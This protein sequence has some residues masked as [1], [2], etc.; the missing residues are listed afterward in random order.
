MD[1]Q[2]FQWD[3][4]AKLPIIGIIRNIGSDAVREILP[5]YA[6]AG[7][8]TLEITMNTPSATTMIGEAQKT[9][10][11]RLQIGAGTVCNTRELDQALEAGA[12]FIV[13][14]LTDETIIKT[15]VAHHIPVFPGAFTPSE[16]YRAWD[17][18]A[19]MIKIFPATAMG[20]GYIRDLKGPFPQIK[21]VPT[22]GI[23]LE[24][25][26]DYLQAGASG[27]GMG[28][29]L[30]DKKLISAGNWEALGHRFAT[31]AERVAKQV[32]D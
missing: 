13:T 29:L 28:S 22:G 31:L 30:F 11:D 23:T 25:C 12:R 4:F 10:G 3:R 24:N 7:L 14:P 18:G 9:F 26:G 15:C 32:A 27:L 17:L 21:L 1:Q 16:V 8:H 6:D 5:L 2:S 20:P 19:D